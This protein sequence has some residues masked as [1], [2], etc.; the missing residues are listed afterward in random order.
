MREGPW[1]GSTFATYETSFSGIYLCIYAY[2]VDNCFRKGVLPG[3]M[4]EGPWR[5]STFATYETS[6]SGIYLCIY[7][8]LPIFLHC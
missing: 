3:V 6:F 5:G 2:K 8:G 1:R 7:Y 4:G